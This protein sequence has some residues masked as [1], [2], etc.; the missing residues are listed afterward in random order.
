[1]GSFAHK[2]LT[3]QLLEDADAIIQE[4]CAENEK[5]AGVYEFTSVQFIRR[6]AQRNQS[7][8]RW[9]IWTGLRASL[10]EERALA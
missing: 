8:M 2:D 6:V 10:R 4:L 3:D 1:M 5:T 9:K 7:V